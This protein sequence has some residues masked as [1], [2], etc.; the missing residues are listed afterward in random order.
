MKER[1]DLYLIAISML[2][3]GLGEGLFFIFQPLY[4]QELGASSIMIGTILGIN[5][6]GMGFMQIPMGYIS[7]RYGRRMM[8]WMSWILGVLSTIVM[9]FANNLTIFVV[10]YLLYGLTAAVIAPMNSYA[11]AARGNWSVG[12][13]VSF[14]S[15]AYNVGALVG[16]LVGGALAERFGLSVLYKIAAGIFIISSI[17]VLFIRK[18]PV[19]KR[20]ELATDKGLHRNPRFVLALVIILVVMFALYLPYPLTLNFLQNER[21]LSLSNIGILGSAVSVASVLLILVLGHLHPLKAFVI[22]QVAMISFCLLIWKGTSLPWYIVAYFLVGG[23]RLSQSLKSAL[24]RPFVGNHEVGLAFG[25]TEAIGHVAFIIAP[26]LAGFLY[27]RNPESVYMVGLI[28]LGVS[29]AFTLLAMRFKG[30][31][32]KRYL[33][34][35]PAGNIGNL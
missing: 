34:Q 16:P 4:M 6:V 32:K 19:E 17:I 25:I 24:V 3:W 11:A 22:G 2:F 12:K 20:D 28:V 5:S 31:F 27:D 23:F 26:I 29:L 33:E 21:D 35:P 30:A 14:I 9:A 10:G 15:A 8:L 1:R 18:Q 13:A 7:D